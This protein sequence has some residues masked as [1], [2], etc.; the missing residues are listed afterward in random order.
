MCFEYL[1]YFRMNFET[2]Y[3]WALQNEI[4]DHVTEARLVA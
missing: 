4:K 2:R 1:S 3:D